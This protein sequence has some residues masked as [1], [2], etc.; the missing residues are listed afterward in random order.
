[1]TEFGNQLKD[2][3]A[4]IHPESA[5]SIL[6]SAGG[7]ASCATL[8]ALQG[9]VLSFFELIYPLDFLENVS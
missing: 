6:N 5:A 4:R 3:V 7:D 2:D 9:G 8:L 1:V